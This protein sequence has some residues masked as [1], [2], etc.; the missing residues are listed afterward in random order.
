MSADPVSPLLDVSGRP[1]PAM[2]ELLVPLGDRDT[3]GFW[4]ACGRGKLAVQA[5][6]ACGR[7]RFP[8]RPMCPHCR[9]LARRWQVTGGEGTIWSFAVIHAP[10]LPAYAPFVPY[11]VV[12]V[13][14]P[15]GPGLRMVGNVVAQ[16]GAA[17]NSVEPSVLQIGARVEVSF[18]PQPEGHAMPRWVLLPGHGNVQ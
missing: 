17:L 15:E 8:P 10:V 9:S 18:E 14:L 12:I 11:P 5:C 4:E 16:P 13:E 1:L 2:N 7:L 6:E 3:S